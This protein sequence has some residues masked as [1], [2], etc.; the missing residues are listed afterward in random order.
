MPITRQQLE[1]PLQKLA[2]SLDSTLHA[3]VGER[4]GFALLV[5][6]FGDTG[7]V[8]YVSN[9]QRPEM[10]KALQEILAKWESGLSTDPRGPKA[11]G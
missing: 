8:A 5:F 2:R 4:V 9:A 1:A 3:Q 11:E 6:D 10:I 7:N